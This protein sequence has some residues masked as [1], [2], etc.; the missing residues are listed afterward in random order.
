EYFMDDLGVTGDA[1]NVTGHVPRY[2]PGRVRALACSSSGDMVFVAVDAPD[3]GAQV[4]AYAV[5]W[6]GDEKIQSAWSKWAISGV[7]KVVHMHAIGDVLYVVAEA[8][9]GGVELLK[10]GLTLNQ[11]DT[12]A[13]EDYTFLLDRLAV[14]EP[15]H[16]EFGN[17]TDIPVP[18]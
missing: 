5:K 11:D 6:A 9:G 18:Y 14:V 1:A 10:I 3:G 7:G 12:D 13:T 16:H 15:V 2:I 4:Y 17:Y 8:P